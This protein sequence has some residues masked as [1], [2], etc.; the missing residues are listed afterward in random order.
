MK[1][2]NVGLA[3]GGCGLG[4][5]AVFIIGG[6]FYQAMYP[7]QNT[8]LVKRINSPMLQTVLSGVRPANAFTTH[9]GLL[10][11][12]STLSIPIQEPAQCCRGALKFASFSC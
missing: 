7:V 4:L 6:I 10:L 12:P 2:G 11:P 9:A 3:A 1:K 5:T 8:S